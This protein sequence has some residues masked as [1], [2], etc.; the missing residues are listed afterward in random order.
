MALNPARGLVLPPNRLESRR[1]RP[2]RLVMI[3]ALFVGSSHARSTATSHDTR[4]RR[5]S[6]C[7][8]AAPSWS[9]RR[10]A[11]GSRGHGG[12][13]SARQCREFS[14]ALWS[15]R[16]S[17]SSRGVILCFRK[18]FTARSLIPM[19]AAISPTRCST[20]SPHSNASIRS[21]FIFSSAIT[22]WPNGSSNASA[23]A[24]STRTPGLNGA[25]P[26]RTASS[27]RRS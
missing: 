6:V 11:G 23:R 9:G 25:S 21:A 18:W 19:T 1:R 5:P 14:P 13:R 2:G 15:G 24:T 7:F 8:D 3:I 20:C 27:R 12:R 16:T 17:R 26:L 10:I 4:T 22:N